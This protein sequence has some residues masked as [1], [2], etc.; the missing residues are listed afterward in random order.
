MAFATETRHVDAVR[1]HEDSIAVDALLVDERIGDESRAALNPLRGIRE[2]MSLDGEQ[3]SMAGRE[4]SSRLADHAMIA[5]QIVGVT[6][7]ARPVEILTPSAAE[8]VDDVV[9]PVACSR[10]RGSIENDH[11]QRLPETG[12]RN[13]FDGHGSLAT[14]LASDHVDVLTDAKELVG[15]LPRYV[16]DAAGVGSEA[17]DDDRDAQWESSC[18]VEVDV[19]SVGADSLSPGLRLVIA[20]GSK[21]PGIATG[22]HGAR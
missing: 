11:A 17:F 20:V 22:I 1:Q 4:T 3:S 8:A 14:A 21:L 16:F 6:A 13:P 19:G 10:R 5:H 18:S 12:N 2:D 9:G 15:N 7:S